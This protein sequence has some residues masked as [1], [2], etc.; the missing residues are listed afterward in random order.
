MITDVW[1]ITGSWY[2]KTVN[3]LKIRHFAEHDFQEPSAT[4]FT[5]PCIQ[6]P[7]HIIYS[8][9]NKFHPFKVECQTIFS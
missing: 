2:D 4:Y 1:S 5:H 3:I 6:Y 7:C 8:F 9:Q